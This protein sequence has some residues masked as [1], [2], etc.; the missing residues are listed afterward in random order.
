MIDERPTG[1]IAR[2]TL[3]DRGDAL[4]LR[5]DTFA[6]GLADRLEA[7]G[8]AR[9]FGDSPLLD[10]LTHRWTLPEHLDG[11]LELFDLDAFAAWGADWTVRAG[12]DDILYDSPE[13]GYVIPVDVVPIDPD[14][15][16]NV[17]ARTA[18][19]TPRASVARLRP[20][21]PPQ[22]AAAPRAAAPSPAPADRPLV[23]P[24]LA[25]SPTRISTVDAPEIEP[26]G[27]VPSE[28]VGADATPRLGR[29]LAPTAGAPR[30][31][32]GRAAA[33]RERYRAAGPDRLTPYPAAMGRAGALDASMLRFPA[34]RAR[35]TGDRPAIIQAAPTVDLTA[36]GGGFAPAARGAER[37]VQALVDRLVPSA[38]AALSAWLIPVDGAPTRADGASSAEAAGPLAASRPS[39]ADPRGAPFPPVAIG[40][41]PP[42]TRQLGRWQSLTA[43]RAFAVPATD[44]AP[45]GP[46][47][48]AARIDALAQTVLD[49][50]DGAAPHVGGARHF[51]L[52]QPG[53]L[54]EPSA[55]PVGG[56]QP[57]AS[58]AARATRA[59]EARTPAA[60]RRADGAA[61]PAAAAVAARASMTARPGVEQA[62]VAPGQ[63]TARGRFGAR[64]RAAVEPGRGIAGGISERFT[65]P[66]TEPRLTANA[67]LL[68]ALVGADLPA[69]SIGQPTRGPAFVAGQSAARFIEDAVGAAV[70]RFADRLAVG[71]G[72]EPGAAAAWPLAPTGALVA[73][74]AERAEPVIDGRGTTR[75]RLATASPDAVPQAASRATASPAVQPT[76]AR[77]A[78]VSGDSTAL[79]ASPTTPTDHM[80]DAAS[81]SPGAAPGDMRQ[82]A[83]GAPGRV[84]RMSAI[85]ALQ[86]AWQ[87]APVGE[88]ARAATALAGQV[89]ARLEAMVGG[90]TIATGVVERLTAALSGG[91]RPALLDALRQFEQA[92]D[93]VTGARVWSRISTL[94]DLGPD[95]P[96]LVQPVL[97]AAG[98]DEAA[99]ATAIAEVRRAAAQQAA[100]AEQQQA[101]QQQAARATQQ[102]AAQQ[103]ATQQQATQQQAARATQQQAAQQQVTQQQATQQQATQQQAARAAQQQAT[104]QQIERAEQRQAEQRQVA[105]HTE[106]QR[107]EQQTRTER[108]FERAR[109][110]RA[111]FAVVAR[112]M[113][114]LGATAPATLTSQWAQWAAALQPSAVTGDRW[115]ATPTGPQLAGWV[116]D[117]SGQTW[118]RPRTSV[119]PSPAPLGVDARVGPGGRSEALAAQITD[120]LGSMAD[121]PGDRP[122]AFDFADALS[123]EVPGQVIR[124]DRG[125]ADPGRSD[126]VDRA[127]SA[128]SASAIS[129]ATEAAQLV[130]RAS[131][132]AR[133]VGRPG[134]VGQTT[135]DIADA[136]A[137]RPASL[138]RRGTARPG[139]RA[140]PAMAGEAALVAGRSD[141]RTAQRSVGTDQSATLGGTPAM[142]AAAAARSSVRRRAILSSMDAAALVESDALIAPEA[143]MPDRLASWWRAATA[144]A[145]TGEGAEAA[146]A[147]A[148]AARVVV[149]PFGE[150]RRASGGQPTDV[151]R[152]STSAAALS[153]YEQAAAG[154]RGGARAAAVGRMTSPT[155]LGE[156]LA[157]STPPSGSEPLAGR[158][159]GDRGPQALTA[160][161]RPRV[162]VETGSAAG[163]PMRSAAGETPGRS[164]EK[165][166]QSRH[167]LAEQ[168]EGDLSPE[169]INEIAEEVLEML[170]REVEF[171]S[172]R[173]GEDEWD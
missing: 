13:A 108:G 67:L 149:S 52:E 66:T 5:F 78:V 30:L 6:G 59:D 150:A 73:P 7:F 112:R 48:L 129:P 43:G 4:T 130:E 128:G 39:L 139:E 95:A 2:E 140:L 119:G 153:V 127:V 29:R 100:R 44:A 12:Y 26:L 155:E 64:T 20:V 141:P 47:G 18:R 49:R 11:G 17:S 40:A 109:A 35:L 131:R 110:E 45:A 14:L 172:A 75:T 51:D 36:D 113:G 16:P 76:A 154:V 115:S 138:R 132:L 87:G 38:P 61:S 57:P 116:L 148:S 24:L 15:A 85:D 97:D 158:L 144:P 28:D 96:A 122:R 70:G 137:A 145:T 104:Q 54:I 10:A 21:R 124:V 168:M 79:L 92:D 117:P 8:V 31:P 23:S 157:P 32:T 53:V 159:F 94:A 114:R 90:E 81:T 80:T 22:A 82:P 55:S 46:L 50:V 93:G 84:I 142:A 156:L 62:F 34:A 71:V 91:A 136:L 152:R 147:D 123:A 27:A 19:R 146:F 118:I 83:A 125:A 25:P 63:T 58:P 1:P 69:S 60:E 162:L 3:S 37:G 170:R 160:P 106:Q 68:D 163:V 105:R 56:Q 173:L 121:S 65:R 167:R 99:V 166:E 101:A 151:S 134:A 103:Q 120:A 133:T 98:D 135:L 74:L 89:G 143:R 165:N 42:A 126:R 41:L 111:A 77:A 33:A 171:N 161:G 102:Q 107:V 86:T 72:G 9:A 88:V 169:E 164:A